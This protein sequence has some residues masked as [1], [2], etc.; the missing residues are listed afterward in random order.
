LDREIISLGAAL[1]GLVAA[2][3][4]PYALQAGEILWSASDGSCVPRT[5]V[6]RGSTLF[7]P[8][9]LRRTRVRRLR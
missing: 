4:C 3:M 1:V 5:A 7:G 6:D 8:G 9:R 2:Y